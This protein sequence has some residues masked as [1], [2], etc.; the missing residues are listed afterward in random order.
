MPDMDIPLSL[1]TLCGGSLEE[2]FQRL[3]PALLGQ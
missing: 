1:S 3:Y 2:H